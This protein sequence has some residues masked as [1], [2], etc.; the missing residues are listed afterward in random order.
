MSEV[1]GRYCY[2]W[3]FEVGPGFEL[4][5]GIVASNAITAGS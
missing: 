5:V 1:S 3:N 2:R 4:E